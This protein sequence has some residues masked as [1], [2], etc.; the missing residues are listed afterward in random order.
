MQKTSFISALPIWALGKE[1]EWNVHLVLSATIEKEGADL[2]RIA[3]HGFYQLFINNQFV[4]YGPARA[5]RDYF[6]VDEISITEQLDKE[7]NKIE[8]LLVSYGVDN[9]S[10]INQDPFVTCEVTNAGEVVYAT[11]KQGFKLESQNNYWQSVSKH[12]FQRGFAES[13]KIGSAYI[14]SQVDIVYCEEKVYIKRNVKYPDYPRLMPEKYILKGRCY[15]E[16][17]ESYYGLQAENT[18][19]CMR[20]T[21]PQEDLTCEIQEIVFEDGISLEVANCNNNTISLESGEYV[22]GQFPYECTGVIYFACK[23][24]HDAVLYVTFD[25]MLTDNK[26]NSQRLNCNTNVKYQL[27]KGE[28]QLVTFEPNS[29]KYICFSAF[30]AGVEISD[31]KVIEIKHCPIEKTLAVGDGMLKNIY[32]AAIETFR[33]N[34]V[35]IFMDCPSRERAGWLCDSFFTGRAEKFFTGENLIEKNFLENFLMEKNYKY[36]P[37]NMLP[38]CYPADHR[39]GVY[40]PNWAMWL[41]IE[42]YDYFQRSGDVE[43]VEQFREKLYGLYDFFKKYEN[44]DGL[45]ERLDKWIMIDWSASNDHV[46][47]VNFPSNM[48]Y[49]FM[50]E[51]MGQLYGDEELKDKAEVIR[52]KIRELSICGDFFCDNLL[53]TEDG[54]IQSGVCSESCQYYA[55]FTKT[56]TPE[57]DV[58][59]WTILVNEFG[60]ER[61]AKGL[62]PEIGVS[63]AFVGNFL[64]LES[65]ANAGMW[66]KL[67]A[68]VEGY[69]GY[70][71]E[72]TGTLWEK[73]DDSASMNHGFASY[74]AVWIAQCVKELMIMSET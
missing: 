34:A 12:T 5:G 61:M 65:L 54:Y 51:R 28:Y 41:V 48:M 57:Q 62:Y 6:R 23:C 74:V 3:T 27:E 18:P 38:M 46:Q 7:Q 52:R 13:Y 56:A 26:V 66:E 31:V 10:N 25:E 4:A 20:F 67:L 58:K 70:M 63:N 9:F 32:D 16:K 29:L 44:K 45:L 64:R 22:I 37:E 55:F 33:Q 8:I 17:K 2:L 30:G 60:P 40:I 53:T 47:D 36:L 39:D 69:F 42:L 59:L 50:L 72:R 24:E 68:E 73:I 43:L 11:G 35:D 19:I 14:P 21:D 71:A 49:A 15:K 1:K